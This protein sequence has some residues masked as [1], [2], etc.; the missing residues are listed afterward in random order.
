MSST[1]QQTRNIVHH[2]LEA[3]GAVIQQGVTRKW[4]TGSI[5]THSG[6]KCP[7]K[8]CN[9]GDFTHVVDVV[10]ECDPSEGDRRWVRLEVRCENGRGYFLLI[11][12]HAGLTRLE[13][14]LIDGDVSPFAEGARR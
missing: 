8:G 3:M 12:N 7:Y 10:W 9:C 11:R 6:L 5:S 14:K 13:Y 1:D 2:E 4:L